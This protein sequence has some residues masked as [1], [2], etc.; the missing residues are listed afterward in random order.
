MGYG[1]VGPAPYGTGIP[2]WKCVGYG[3]CDDPLCSVP[4]WLCPDVAKY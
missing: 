4:D 3:N 2:P 1:V